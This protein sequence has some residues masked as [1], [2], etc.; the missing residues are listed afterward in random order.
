[1]TLERALEIIDIVCEE[2][3]RTNYIKKGLQDKWKEIDVEAEY[4]GGITG[5]YSVQTEQ[6]EGGSEGDGEHM[7]VVFKITDKN[8]GEFGF[9]KMDGKYDSWNDCFYYGD[10]L[11]MVQPKEVT[12]IVYE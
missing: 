9:L 3:G 12:V 4:T 7:H 11:K 2:T 6:K 5:D 10:R 8:T 1:M